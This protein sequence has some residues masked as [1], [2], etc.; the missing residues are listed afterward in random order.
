MRFHGIPGHSTPSTHS[1]F[2]SAFSKP[3]SHPPVVVPLALT[4]PQKQCLQP[5]GRPRVWLGLRCIL[6]QVSEWAV[7]HCGC[8]ARWALT[9]QA[10]VSRSKQ[11]EEAVLNPPAG[12]P[13]LH[14]FR[15]SPGQIQVSHF[16]WHLLQ[17]ASCLC[18]MPRHGWDPG[19]TGQLVAAFLPQL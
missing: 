15:H 16:T 14:R 9:S 13:H 18:L 17:A 6:L 12:H 3:R 8:G 7:V 11:V 1:R 2:V 5:G 10:S 19:A 4:H